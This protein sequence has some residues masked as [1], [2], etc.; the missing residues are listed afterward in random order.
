MRVH[1]L[2]EQL[3]FARLEFTR[4]LVGV[5]DE[6]A[7][8]RFGPMNS[9]SWIVGH[10]ADQEQRY[11]FQRRGVAALFPDLNDLVGYGKPATTPPLDEMQNAWR[12]VTEASNAYLD[13]LTI[14]DLQSHFVVNGTA[15]EESVGTLMIRVIDHYWFHTGEAQAIRQMLGHINLPEYVGDIN[16]FARFRPETE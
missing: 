11:W 16:S 6:E 10:L 15:I 8:T 5:T 7:R 9:I 3:R 4:G 2:V 12:T 13:S 1:P 14:P